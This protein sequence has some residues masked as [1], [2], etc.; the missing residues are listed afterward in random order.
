MPILSKDAFVSGQLD[1]LGA[2]EYFS[3]P[4]MQLCSRTQDFSSRWTILSNVVE[5]HGHGNSIRTHTS[6]FI[7]FLQQLGVSSQTIEDHIYHPCIHI[8]NHTLSSICQTEH[9]YVGASCLGIIEDR[10]SEIS[11]R[12]GSFLIESQWVTQ[13]H[14]QHYTTHK[15]LDV[16]H[17]EDFYQ[18]ILPYWKTHS[19]EIKKGLEIGNYLFLHL[20]K[21]LYYIHQR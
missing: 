20:Y 7:A 12:I 15:D 21:Q 8:F 19:L 2:V 11:F 6:T 18:I 5:E 4:M 13:G 16:L 14:L 1:F 3:L 9:P 10:F 17:A